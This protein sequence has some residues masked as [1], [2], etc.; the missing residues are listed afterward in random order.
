MSLFYSYQLNK[1]G[2]QTHK[3]AWFF[4]ILRCLSMIRKSKS[5]WLM[6]HDC[7][8][9]TNLIPMLQA[10]AYL[11]A[12]LAPPTIEICYA[13]ATWNPF[14]REGMPLAFT[15]RCTNSTES[16]LHFFGL[17]HS[18]DTTSSIH[19]SGLNFSGLNRSPSLTPFLNESNLHFLGVHH[20]LD[21]AKNSK[22]NSYDFPCFAQ[23]PFGWLCE[24][25]WGAWWYELATCGCPR[26]SIPA[27]L[28]PLQLMFQQS[29]PD[30]P[31]SLGPDFGRIVCRKSSS[32]LH[33]QFL[34]QTFIGG[35]CLQLY[36]FKLQ[37][38]DVVLVPRVC[39][40][41]SV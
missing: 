16:R 22:Y 41:K 33:L 6:T 3:Q 1:K 19:E 4:G 9:P 7:V 13:K 15:P 28:V 30:Q 36:R 29:P 20:S 35:M 34:S 25:S 17:Y 8:Q 32:D 14:E 2:H 12:P 27:V 5:A 11:K 10:F 23:D 40:P 24:P 38:W 26:A 37:D 18:L 21:F 39:K 31:T